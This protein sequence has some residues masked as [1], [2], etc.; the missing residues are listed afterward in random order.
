MVH[1]I[2]VTRGRDIKTIYVEINIRSM[3]L[4]SVE[5]HPDML[6]TGRKINQT[7]IGKTS[8]TIIMNRHLK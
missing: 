8:R 4:D 5:L 7:N 2:E 6:V 3:C 1:G